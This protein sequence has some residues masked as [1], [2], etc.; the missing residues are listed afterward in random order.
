MKFEKDPIGYAIHEYEK[1]GSLENIIVK[2]DLCEDD[3]LPIPYLFRTFDLMPEIEQF[4]MLNCEGRVL[5]IGAGAGS[6][7]TYLKEKGYDVLALDKSPGACDYLKRKN[8]KVHNI[9]FKEL[10]S[11]KFDTILLLMNGIGLAATLEK[12]PAALKHLKGLLN[13]G[14]RIFCDSTDITYMYQ[15]DDG[16]I[17][18]DLNARYY[19][20]INFNMLYRNV[21]SG[22]FPWL[23]IDQQTLTDY[24]EK[25]GFHVDIPIE[26][27]NNHYLAELK[28]D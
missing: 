21:E 6:H 14:G 27:E 15:N 10:K 22:W 23:Y 8:I 9:D 5:D 18:M 12:L 26:G 2:S 13:P 19:G 1:S 11:E 7:S 3:L 4:A 16:S 17:W 28:I 20:E 25:M 24:A